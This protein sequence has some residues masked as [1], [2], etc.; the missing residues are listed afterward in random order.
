MYAVIFD[1]DGVIF[2]SEAKVQECWEEIAEKY[3]MKDIQK[4]CRM[5]LGSNSRVVEQIFKQQYGE[6]F[7]YARFSKKVDTLFQERYGEGRLPKKPGILKLLQYLKKH[8][9]KTAVA[10]STNTRVVRQELE[11]GGLLG[12]FDV[13]VGGDMVTK[14]KPDPQIFLEVCK[15]LQISPNETYI[16]EDSYNGI[17]AAYSAGSRPI[18]VPDLLQATEEMKEK[19]SVVLPSLTEVQEWFKEKKEV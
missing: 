7:D 14:S 2:D 15:K 10:S 4:T 12:Y 3:G 9:I 18:M 17:R 1:M 16:I 6:D 8:G 11:E 5:C 19:A 13:I